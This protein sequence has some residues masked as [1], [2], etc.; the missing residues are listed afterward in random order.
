MLCANA[1][2][3]P[4]EILDSLGS[5]LSSKPSCVAIEFVCAVIHAVDASGRRALGWT[6]GWLFRSSQDS[7]G[8]GLDALYFD[9]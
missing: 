3:A 9:R 1:I 8:G 2:S 7:G 6:G 4:S 5:A